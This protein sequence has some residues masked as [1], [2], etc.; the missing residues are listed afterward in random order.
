MIN[1]EWR[2][3][4]IDWYGESRYQGNGSGLAHDEEI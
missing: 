1:E 3:L 4:G 2:D